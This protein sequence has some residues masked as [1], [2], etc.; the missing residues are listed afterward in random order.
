MTPE[1]SHGRGRQFKVR[2]RSEL[3][4]SFVIWPT[5]ELLDAGADIERAGMSRGFEP[6]RSVRR[7]GQLS[8]NRQVVSMGYAVVAVPERQATNGSEKDRGV[9][10]MGRKPI[11]VGGKQ[12]HDGAAYD[13]ERVALRS[14]LT[15]SLS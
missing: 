2:I 3:A 7:C 10:R 12:W 15:G 11:A 13:I 9:A 14:G 6:L 8:K 5:P 1:P 4:L